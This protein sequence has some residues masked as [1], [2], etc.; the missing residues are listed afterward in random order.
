MTKSHRTPELAL[1]KVCNAW[2]REATSHLQGLQAAIGTGDP[3]TRWDEA[4]SCCDAVP[5]PPRPP[6]SA[7]TGLGHYLQ[8]VISWNLTNVCAV[9][10]SS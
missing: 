4:R 10:F 2:E 8:V 1:E 6:F 3:R 5:G 9:T 7:A